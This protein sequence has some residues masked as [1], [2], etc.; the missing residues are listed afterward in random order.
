MTGEDWRPGASLDALRIRARLMD[1]VRAHFRETGALEV[2]TPAL[3][4]AGATDPNLH[5]LATRVTGRRAWLHTSPEF[6]MKRLLAAGAGD[7]WQAARVFRGGEAGRWHNPEFTLIEWYRVGRDYHWLMEEVGGLIGRLLGG[8]RRAGPRRTT[9]RRAFVEHA[10]LDPFEADR[11]RLVA[12][13]ESLGL[14]RQ[15]AA[16]ADRTGLLD[17]IGSLRVYPRLGHGGVELLH[18]FPADQA[19]LARIR[20]GDP[21]VAERFE[22]FVDGMELANGF[23]EL[24]DADEQRR[25]FENERAHRRRLGLP[26]VAPDERLL[27]A[28]EAGLPECSGVALGFDRL[29]ALAAGAGSLDH[30]IAFPFHRA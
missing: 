26:D 4:S 2:D 20:D 11:S 1:A 17:M 7:I 29:A 21:P 15:D 27:A 10:G 3:S 30:V 28:M 19:A 6:P 13:A 8:T 12:L 5:S 16:A 22:A 24:T 18:D 14:G 25:R 23:G 9:Y